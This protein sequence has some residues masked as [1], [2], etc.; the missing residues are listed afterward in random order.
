MRWHLES[1][2]VIDQKYAE[3][4]LNS[5]AGADALVS[6]LWHLEAANVLVEAEGAEILLRA[7]LNDLSPS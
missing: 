6:S 3:S 5:L 1:E 7:R 2:K 4:V